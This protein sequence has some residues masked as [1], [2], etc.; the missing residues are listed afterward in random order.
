[1]RRR[2]HGALI[3]VLPGDPKPDAGLTPFSN[4]PLEDLNALWAYLIEGGDA[5]SRGVS[6]LC[7]RDAFGRGKPAAAAPLMKAGIWWPG[8]GRGR[9]RGVDGGA[10][11]EPEVRVRQEEGRIRLTVAHQPS[12]ARSCRA[13]RRKPVEALIE[14]LPAEGMRPLPVLRLQP[15]G[16]RLQGHPRKRLRRH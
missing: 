15:Q 14:A 6:L 8:R 7:R 3:A 1:M 12:I 11:D 10:V 13:A 9:R 4:V 16:S 5:N 2:A